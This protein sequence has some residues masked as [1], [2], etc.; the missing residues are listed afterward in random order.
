MNNLLI[1]DLIDLTEVFEKNTK[2]NCNYCNNI[3]GFKQWLCDTYCTH[4]LPVVEW[5]GKENGRSPESVISTLIVHLN[6]YAKTYSKAVIHKT[7]FTSQ[8]DF[9]YLINL[10]ALG[11]MSKMQLIKKNVQDKPTGMQIINRLIDKG[12]IDQKK[13][14]T[15]KRSKIIEITPSGKEV[16]ANEMHKIRTATYIVTGTLSH[17]EKLE[18]IRLLNKLEQFHNPIFLQNYGN[19][20]LLERVTEKFITA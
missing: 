16:L 7:E 8:E 12:W 13:S 11:A 10:N 17:H 19:D 5:E 9:V 15:D 14:D 18:L 4:N 1:K 3:E 2:D 20:E 6:R